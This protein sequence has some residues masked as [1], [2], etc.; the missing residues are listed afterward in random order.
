MG[1]GATVAT[2]VLSMAAAFASFAAVA[3]ALAALAGSI[4]GGLT[5]SGTAETTSALAVL[6]GIDAVAVL[7]AFAVSLLGGVTLPSG[8]PQS[9]FAVFL[10]LVAG[11]MQARF[12]AA[13]GDVG[14]IAAQFG[15]YSFIGMFAL[16]V[17]A[18]QAGVH[19]ARW[20]HERRA[21]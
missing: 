18:S 5:A 3:G 19:L 12:F 6:L 21:V 7:L 15:K 20:R 16:A 11:A 4:Y 13:A 8:L 10:P 2:F 9:F 17:I 1:R 14:G